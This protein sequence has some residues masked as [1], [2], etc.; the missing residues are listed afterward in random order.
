MRDLVRFGV[1]L[2]MA[3][4]V[5][6]CGSPDTPAAAA[7]PARGGSPLQPGAPIRFGPPARP[8]IDGPLAT[9]QPDTPATPFT[10]APPVRVTT[11]ELMRRGSGALDR[12]NRPRLT[13]ICPDRR[14]LPNN[15][16][17]P[18]VA[19]WPPAPRFRVGGPLAAVTPSTPNADI[20]VRADTGN[21]T[22][23]DTMGDVGPTQYPVALNGR[24][25]TISKATGL[26]DGVLE[27]RQR[28]L[29]P[30]SNDGQPTGIRGSATTAGPAA[31]TS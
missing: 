17:S 14:A 23:P 18:A 6:A 10:G 8:G 31:G 20:A 12:E 21:A 29:L 1:L 27:P 22:P 25:R 19:Q 11:A 24:V 9:T 4:S 13:K 7:G 3:A 28:R 16:D 30:G 2:A 5:A 15:P 26:A